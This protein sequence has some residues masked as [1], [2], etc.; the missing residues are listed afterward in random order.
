MSGLLPKASKKKNMIKNVKRL[1]NVR[2][3]CQQCED[4][5][6]YR[7]NKGEMEVLNARQ[8]AAARRLCAR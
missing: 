4:W 3:L 7:I 8:G 6:V 2:E 5:A 1:Q